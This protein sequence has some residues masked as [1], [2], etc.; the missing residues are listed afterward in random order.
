MSYGFESYLSSLNDQDANWYED[1]A[2]LQALLR[3][4]SPDEAAAAA[5]D[6]RDFGALSAGRLRE[7]AEESSRPENQPYLRHVDAYN[8]RV[9]DVVLP[10]STH[11]ALAIVEGQHHLPVAVDNPY[12]AYAKGYLFSQNGEAGVGCSVACTDGMIRVLEALGDRREHKDAIHRVRDCTPEKVVHGAQFVTEIQGGSDAGAN[13]VAAK[14]RGDHWTL[15]G[16]K[17]FCSNINADYFVMTARPEGAPEGSRGVGLFLVPAWEDEASKRRNGYT[18]DRLKEK[19]GTRELATAEVNFD[20]A[21]A[22]PIGPLNRGIANILR[23]VL[24]T[25][26]FACASSAAS[27]V[28]RAERVATAYTEFRQAFGRRLVDFPLVREQLAQIRQVRE[29]SLASLFELLRLWR[30]GASNEVDKLD[31]RY[32]MSLAK[33]TLTWD[34]TLAI[35]EAMMLLGGQGIEERFAPLGRIWRDAVIMETWEGPHN[36]LFSQAL[37]DMIRFEVDPRAFVARMAGE[38]RSDLADELAGILSNARDLEAT[39]PF[40]RFGRKLVHA[41]GERALAETR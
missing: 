30:S 37:R 18:I 19:L 9:D 31:F 14:D 2:L 1:D 21:I 38:A 32:M 20:G 26:R 22:Y 33:P 36:V 39:V 16:L 35:H 29:Q 27:F 34:A 12:V 40:A 13:E 25:S 41:F 8:R 4:Y 17:W 11:E 6:L 28:R 7:L 15:H 5:E 24:V 23:H 10:A 3:R